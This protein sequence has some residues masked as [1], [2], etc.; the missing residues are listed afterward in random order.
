MSRN[1]APSLALLAVL[2]A[3]APTAAQE[4]PTER[5]AAREVL[6]KMAALEQSL[7]VPAMVARVGGPDAARDGV[8][9][10]AKALMD[11]ELLALSDDICTHP[12][13][14]YKETRS[15]EKLAAALRAH[16]FDVEIGVGGLETAFVARYQKNN[17]KPD[18]GVAVEYDALRGTD[19]AFHGDQH[20][21]QGPVGIAAAVAIAEYLSANG[22]PGSVT[23][24]GTPA[25][26]LLEPS[27]K[28][29][30]HRAHVFDGMDV[31]VRSHSSTQTSRPAP[32][33][34][35]CCLNIDGVKYTFSGAPAHQMTA[36]NGRNALTAAIHLFNNVDAVRSNIRP[37]ARIQGVITEGGAAPNVVPDRAQA[38]FYIRYPDEVY[39]AQVR[40]FVD[41]AAKAAA[42]ATGT[43]VKIDNYGSN[44]DGISTA[45]LAELAFSYLKRYGAGKVA[46]E[47]GKPQGWEESGSVSRDIP[48]VGFAAY[49]SDWPNHTYG[50]NDD[51]LKP[52]GHDG[53]TV[54]AQAMAALL[55]TYLTDAGY[56]AAAARE[57]AGIKA[58]FGDYLDALG[59][60]Y[61]VPAV[62]DPK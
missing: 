4:T 54:Q 40:A 35:T 27:A 47:P 29:V 10:R 30:L 56:R 1:F 2:L 9:A 43:K 28:T 46:P 51:N 17:G 19:G 3:A 57:F 24:F 59:K 32:G 12:E 50:M 8:A 25:E 33:F 22:L 11:A 58:L 6:Q 18:L 20:C 13:V 23:V 16:G 15:V 34:G 14:G 21:A 26:E 39:L 36:W 45:T 49:T 55:H 31:I 7:D 52:V 44:R 60:A 61:Q 62:P 48:G 38:D 41:D 42:L 5:E 53:F 37:E